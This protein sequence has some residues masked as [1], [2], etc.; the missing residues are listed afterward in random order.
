M[1]DQL[2]ASLNVH[3]QLVRLAHIVLGTNIVVFSLFWKYFWLY[4]DESDLFAM[5]GERLV[6]LP[7]LHR[8]HVVHLVLAQLVGHLNVSHGPRLCFPSP[9]SLLYF[10]LTLSQSLSHSLLSS[11][12][13]KA[14][15]KAA[16]YTSATLPRKLRTHKRKGSSPVDGKF[17]I[18]KA[19]SVPHPEEL[20]SSQDTKLAE[21]GTIV[22]CH[23]LT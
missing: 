8:G 6:D 10:S 11:P 23:L 5:E 17:N 15:W 12:S 9:L 21:D 4:L 13:E 1:S 7:P 3:Q 16:G 22:V 2:V 18:Q 14:R 19:K 20:L